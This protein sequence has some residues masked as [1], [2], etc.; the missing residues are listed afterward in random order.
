MRASW[1][2]GLAVDVIDE[3]DVHPELAQPSAHACMDVEGLTRAN[4]R[5]AEPLGFVRGDW[6]RGT[7][8]AVRDLDVVR[9]AD[10]LVLVLPV[11]GVL[12]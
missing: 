8:A 10:E 6:T 11:K 9:P 7:C 12:E 1:A 4:V 3:L 5:E 2:N